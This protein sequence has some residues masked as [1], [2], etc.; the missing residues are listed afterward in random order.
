MTILS[1]PLV[2]T[3]I[4]LDKEVADTPETVSEAGLVLAEPVV[5]RDAAVVHLLHELGVLPIHQHLVQPL[6]PALL[7]PL[8]AELEVDRHLEPALLVALQGVDP[9]QN[10]SLECWNKTQNIFDILFTLSSVEPLP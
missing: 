10:W 3:L 2:S 7:H 9:A 1:L 4:Y 6:A 5:V 8:E